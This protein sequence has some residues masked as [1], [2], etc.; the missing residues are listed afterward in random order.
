MKKSPEKRSFQLDSK[1]SLRKSTTA[2]SQATLH[3]LKARNEAERMK[4]KMVKND[5]P[6]PTQEELLEEATQTEKENLA[7]LEK[8]KRMELEKKK[9]RPTKGTTYTG[10]IIRY[11]SLSM[12]V[13]HDEQKVKEIVEEHEEKKRTTRRSRMA[14]TDAA[15]V[16][17]KSR[18]ER[19]FITFENDINNKVFESTFPSKPKKSRTSNLCAVTRLPA[20]YFDPVSQL[21]YHN[22]MAFKI[23]RE[24]FYQ[25]LETSGD[26]TDGETAAWLAWRKKWKEQRAA[27]AIK[28]EP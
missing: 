23:I 26:H 18:C 13:V 7:S 12:P 22:I 6:I 4:P 16:A 11:Q 24:S 28:V 27:K 5:D 3:R 9:V 17:E 15:K 14:A 1:K 8:F 20:K 25:M 2:K 19:T 10:P 21:P